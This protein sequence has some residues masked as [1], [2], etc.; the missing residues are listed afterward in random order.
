MTKDE[1]TTI[2]G[3]P[4]SRMADNDG[5]EIWQYR[6]NALEG[7]AVKIMANIT[8]FGLDTAVDAEYQDIL[9][10]TF[11]TNVVLKAT[12]EENVHNLT[13]LAGHN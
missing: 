11:Q 4:R 1:V 7:K 3:E 10:V 8:S 6:K 12:Y 13:P 2:L 9:T 5:G